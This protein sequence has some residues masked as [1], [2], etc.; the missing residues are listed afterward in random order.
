MA[1]PTNKHER[2]QIGNKKANKIFPIYYEDHTPESLPSRYGQLRKTRK[3]CSNP[4]CCGNPRRAKGRNLL[5]F[6]ER[7]WNIEEN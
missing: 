3:P 6:Q 7:K 1:H 5:T 2:R 4:D